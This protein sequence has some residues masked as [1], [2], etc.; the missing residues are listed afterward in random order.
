MTEMPAVAVLSDVMTR[1]VH[2]VAPFTTVKT[3]ARLLTENQVGAL[4]VVDTAGFV[5]GVVSEADL[6]ARVAVVPGTGTGTTAAGVMTSPAVIAPPDLPVRKAAQL[7]YKRQVRHLPVV[8]ENGRLQGIVSRG[9]LLRL[10]LRGDADLKRRIEGD[11]LPR[12]AWLDR[13]EVAID[14]EGGV[15][16]VRG[17]VP[18]RS[19]VEAL[20]RLIARVDGVVG[21][22]VAGLMWNLDDVAGR[23]AALGLPVLPGI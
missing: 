10:F 20:T 9:D 14:V 4:P 2:V 13:E 12:L 15:V 1:N 23:A 19:D 17:S 6:V 5:V 7:M 21:V 11:L 3:V 16:D 18:R 22:A 8:D